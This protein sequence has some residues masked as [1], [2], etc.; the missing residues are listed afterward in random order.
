MLPVTC[1]RSDEPLELVA[2]L[3]GILPVDLRRRFDL[4]APYDLWVRITKSSTERYV[5]GS[6]RV[7]APARL[8]RPLSRDDLEALHGA[9][10]SLTVRCLH[11]R[12]LARRVALAP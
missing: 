2:R 3:R 4:R 6:V 1:A 7:R 10:L 5:N 12:F 9:R 8:G 11:S